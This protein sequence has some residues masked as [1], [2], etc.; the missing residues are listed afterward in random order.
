[1][2]A[3]IKLCLNQ[4]TILT[5]HFSHVLTKI[6]GIDGHSLMMN[7]TKIIEKSIQLETFNGRQKT[8]KQP[9]IKSNIETVVE[10]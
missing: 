1:M 5:N 2:V 6:F 3:N 9:G 4:T 8:L 7:V 10:Y